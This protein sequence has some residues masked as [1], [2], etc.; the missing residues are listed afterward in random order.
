MG[1]PIKNYMALTVF[2]RHA[3]T[4]KRYC[5]WRYYVNIVF[6]IILL[7]LL[8]KANDFSL[9]KQKFKNKI[10]LS[11]NLLISSDLNIYTFT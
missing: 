5:A 8:T 4:F 2:V 3:K 6:I 1:K 10:H 7:Q 9:S 11:T